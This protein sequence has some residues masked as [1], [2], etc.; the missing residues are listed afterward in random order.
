[1]IHLINI[2]KSF[3]TQLL[4]D[5]ITLSIN[6]REKIGLVGKNGYGKTTLFNLI[7]G[8]T[9]PDYG[10][11]SIPKNYRIGHLEQ[12]INFTQDSVLKEGCLGLREED[13]YDT[14]KVEKILSGLGFSKEDMN[15]NPSVFSG[16]Y[17]IR[18][19]LAKVLVA[20]PNLLLLDEPNNYLD[21]VASRWL[22][23]FLRAWKNEL[24]VITHDRGFMDSFTTHTVTIHRRK[25]RKLRGT[26]K[27]IHEQI[28]T[29]ESVYEK[30]RLND[31][32]KR[33]QLTV[34]IDRFRAKARLAGQVQSKILALEKMDEKKQLEKIEKLDFSFNA[35][36]FVSAQMLA[37][38]EVSFSYDGK[39]PYL[40]KDFSLNVGK[41]E[42]I[43]VIGKNG[44][45][46][47]TLM[48]LL[49]SE[50]SPIKGTIK[51]NPGLK[52]GYFGQPNLLRL[53]PAN[54]VLDEIMSASP[55]NSLQAAR[56]I[57]GML[58]FKEDNALKQ[59]SVISG[60]E[61]NRVMLAKIVITPCQILLLDEPSNHLDMDSSE[62]LMEAVNE[63]EGSVIMVT[64][65]E[66][67]L[68]GIAKRLIIFDEDKVTLYEGGYQDFLD[69]IG[70]RDEKDAQEETKV[71][72]QVKQDY[73]KTDGQSNEDIK[74]TKANIIK[75]RDAAIKPLR[76]EIN[77]LEKSIINIEKELNL[78]VDILIKAIAHGNVGQITDNSKKHKYLKEELDSLYE[79][80]D[81]LTSQ[82][83]SKKKEFEA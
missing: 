47:S 15:K 26:T 33:R 45:G 58:M 30:T 51:K 44:K 57:A 10:E 46:K 74:I 77:K 61:K 8:N 31:E 14:W 20:E 67:F 32:N 13:K 65:N 82:Y 60:G 18:L 41:K 3:G 54:T 36:P 34:F 2:T 55:S 62:A 71:S 80:F 35:I 25:I 40:I 6:S 72:L 23:N 56:N 11:I 79:K 49:A 39:E 68:K 66:M 50:L 52:I 48:N 76:S 24:V 63:F 21:I 59:V 19:N 64:H 73:H 29:E 12:H 17:Q 42:R 69:R 38:K 75:E 7:L 5:D 28:E 4:Y 22:L 9:Q 1:M 27:K 16:G 70:W 43:C 53:N 83:E 37:A 78:C 81:K